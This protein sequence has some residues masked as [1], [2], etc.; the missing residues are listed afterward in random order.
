MIQGVEII[1]SYLVGVFLS[2]IHFHFSLAY[3]FFAATA[4]YNPPSAVLSILC[5]STYLAK[6]DYRE[7]WCAYP[8]SGLVHTHELRAPKQGPRNA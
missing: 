6:R 5:M 2:I 7:S 3:I 1:G 4:V 8:G